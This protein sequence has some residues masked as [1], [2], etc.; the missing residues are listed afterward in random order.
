M[1]GGGKSLRGLRY[2]PLLTPN[3]SQQF[4]NPLIALIK[5]GS[6]CNLARDDRVSDALSV[7]SYIPSPDHVCSA[8]G[9]ASTAHARR[10]PRVE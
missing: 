5:C 4:L 8:L 2:D 9:P 10:F 6:L 7:R 1:G 3:A